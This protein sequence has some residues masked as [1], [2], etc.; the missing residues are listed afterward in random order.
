MDV[1]V[2]AGESEVSL[3]HLNPLFSPTSFY[4]SAPRTVVTRHG[5]AE[6]R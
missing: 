5:P 6:H 4:G 1:S 3:S 2:G